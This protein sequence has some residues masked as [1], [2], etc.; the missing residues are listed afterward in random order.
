MY[1]YINHVLTNYLSTSVGHSEDEEIS[2]LRKD[3]ESSPELAKGVMADLEK[4]F[5]RF[6]RK[7]CLTSSIGS[8]QWSSKR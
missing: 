3:L 4:A 2:I 7:S 6:L 8:F 1:E 5:R